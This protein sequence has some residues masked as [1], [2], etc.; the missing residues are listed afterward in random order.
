MVNYRRNKLE[1]SDA[2]YFITMVTKGRR[3]L[4]IPDVTSDIIRETM[5]FMSADLD[6]DFLAWVILPDHIHWL[7][8]PGNNDYSD[9]VF[10][11]KRRITAE[12]RRE[13]FIT[14]NTTIWQDRFWERTVR[15]ENEMSNYIEYIHYNPIKHGWVDCVA[16]WRYSSYHDYVLDGIYPDD[17]RGEANAT[18]QEMEFYGQSEDPE[19]R[20]PVSNDK[21][22]STGGRDSGS[23]H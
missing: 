8:K 10:S 4:F 3:H 5:F 7:I 16:N 23:T 11:Y 2:V 21:T 15:N 20:P 19:S 9:I 1:T 6:F 18:I 14:P 17:L 22:R 13:G 12:F